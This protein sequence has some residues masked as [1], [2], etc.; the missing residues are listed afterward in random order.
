MTV[1]LKSVLANPSPSNH[2]LLRIDNPDAGEITYKL[3]EH[4]EFKLSFSTDEI[5]VEENGS[6]QYLGLY[7][8]GQ[9]LYVGLFKRY[10]VFFQILGL[11]K[12]KTL[13]Y[14]T[15]GI[16]AVL[17][18]SCRARIRTGKRDRSNRMQ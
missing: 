6:T 15:A 4:V 2:A 9:P 17:C 1:D 7:D 10:L 8:S 16:S 14:V 3:H 13:P 12:G 11:S 18:N 5:F